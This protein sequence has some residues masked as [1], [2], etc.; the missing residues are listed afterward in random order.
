MIWHA[1]GPDAV[2]AHLR[3]DM[4]RGLSAAEALRR[5]LEH[6]ANVLTA[7][8]P[9]SAVRV[10]LQQFQSVVVW[11][12]IG[13]AGSRSRSADQLADRERAIAARGRDDHV[14][15]DL[16]VAESAADR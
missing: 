12:L 15:A 13:A 8:P 2:A 6:G 10:F 7:A 3:T 5:R 11:I 1:E 9:V 14:G 16:G 4:E